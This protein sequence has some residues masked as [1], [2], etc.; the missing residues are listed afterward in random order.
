MTTQ[1]TS[2]TATTGLTNV[3]NEVVQKTEEGYKQ[4]VESNAQLQL[5]AAQANVI[6][7]SDSGLA[8]ATSNMGRNF[9][10]IAR[11]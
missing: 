5:M 8:Q 11:G 10:D 6:M 9:K 3:N 7:N 2:N 4:M 1:I